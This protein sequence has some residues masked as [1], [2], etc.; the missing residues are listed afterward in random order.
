MDQESSSSI[1]EKVE[2]QQLDM[3]ILDLGYYKGMVP[4]IILG[5]NELISTG[6]V[7]PASQVSEF[8]EQ[9]LET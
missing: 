5:G 7:V 8:I 2:I 4:T 9:N 3:M 1:C 6:K